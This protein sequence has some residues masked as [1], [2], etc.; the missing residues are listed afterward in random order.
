MRGEGDGEGG[1]SVA[2]TSICQRLCP[3]DIDGERVTTNTNEVTWHTG[4][5]G[6]EQRHTVP[7]GPTL[8]SHSDMVSSR[9]QQA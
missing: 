5:C 1:V 7:H 9:V 4:S 3:G 8:I 6:M 2:I